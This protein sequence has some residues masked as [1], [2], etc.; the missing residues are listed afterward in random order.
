MDV[1]APPAPPAPKKPKRW[2]WIIG[3]VLSLFVGIGIGAAAGSKD[4]GT[5]AAPSV[6]GTSP[7][8]TLP[9]AEGVEPTE[10]PAETGGTGSALDDPVPVGAAAHVGQWTVK[11][12]GYTPNATDAVHRENQFNDKPGAGEQYVLV[13][14]R[15]TYEGDG[16]SDPYFDQTWAVVSTDGTLHEEAGQVWPDQLSDAGN[17]PSGASAV[18][19]VGFLVKSAEVRGLTLYVEADTADFEKEGAFLALGG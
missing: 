7:S 15:T 2:P 13:T 9:P 6:A 17:V 10:P 12:V 4:T 11:V 16:S 19:N 18:G 5:T 8:T 1:P 3:M 14:L